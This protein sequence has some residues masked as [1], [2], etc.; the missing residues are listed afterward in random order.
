MSDT[1]KN[2]ALSA[3][4][5][6]VEDG[7]QSFVYGRIKKI[8]DP[9]LK[10]FE[11]DS[12]YDQAMQS[13]IQTLSMGMALYAYTKITKFFF[14]R[15][16]KI[17]TLL[18]SYIVAGKV[19][20][21][22]SDKLKASKFKGYKAVK[23]LSLMLDSDRTSDRIQI[24]KLIQTNVNQYDSHKFH[25][26]N[27]YQAKET[28]I[29]NTMLPLSNFKQSYDQKSFNK[30]QDLTRRAAWKNTA[31][32]KNIYELATGFK[33][34]QTGEA[35]WSKLY[36]ELNKYTEFFITSEKDIINLQTAVMK[37]VSVKG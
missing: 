8:T 34:S 24:A 14:E 21:R 33:L 27:Q 16:I 26:Q 13:F 31:E 23:T 37:L 35:S 12:E 32:H 22:I 7:V 3:F 6:G 2:V 5:N 15:S 11:G 9:F 17:G 10:K 30:F 29:D 20:K 18:W 1:V 19:K 25:F 36:Q 4:E 28:Q